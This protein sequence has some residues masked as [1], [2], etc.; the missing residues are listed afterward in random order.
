[1]AASDLTELLENRFKIF[2]GDA[3]TGIVDRDLYLAISKG[4]DQ[5]D[6]TES[7]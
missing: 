3:D 2:R 5:G 6:R 7:R 1:L 4:P